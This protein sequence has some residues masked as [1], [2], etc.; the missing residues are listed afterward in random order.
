MALPYAPEVVRGSQHPSLACM[1][2]SLSETALTATRREDRQD[3]TNAAYVYGCVQRV[4][5]PAEERRAVRL[6]D[7]EQLRAWSAPGLSARIQT[8]VLWASSSEGGY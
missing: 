4:R 7:G 5:S 8:V 1:S 3:G 2:A 6:S